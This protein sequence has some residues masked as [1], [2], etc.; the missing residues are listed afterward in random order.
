MNQVTM[1]ATA[2]GL[3][4]AS[5]AALSVLYLIGVR[6]AVEAYKTESERLRGNAQETV[7]RTEELVVQGVEMAQRRQLPDVWRTGYQQGYR[8]GSTQ[9]LWR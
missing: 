1:V 9:Q 8:A 6:R 3:G 5:A 4:F 7:R 2:F